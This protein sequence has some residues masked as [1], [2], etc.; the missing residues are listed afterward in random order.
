MPIHIDRIVLVFP[1]T[2]KRPAAASLQTLEITDSGREFEEL[3]PLDPTKV[4]DYATEFNLA[5]LGQVETLTTDLAK[6]TTEYDSEVVKVTALK[7][8]N[9]TLKTTIAKLQNPDVIPE[10]NAI[11]WNKRWIDPVKFVLRF[12]P[13][14]VHRVYTSLDLTLMQGRELL[15]AYILNNYYIDLD[16]ERVTGLT[17]Y[18][19]TT[20]LPILTP[21]ER[22]EI[23]RDSSS[24]ERYI[25]TA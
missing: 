19:L 22:V 12:T 5:A 8:E 15:N 23:L 17:A 21:E 9:E 25:P 20:N 2:G 6:K 13:I 18:M 10:D 1:I 7:A 24:S 14:Q 11:E 4:N 16:D 3:V